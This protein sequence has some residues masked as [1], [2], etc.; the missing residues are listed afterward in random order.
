MSAGELAEYV[1][2]AKCS[3]N[4][5]TDSLKFDQLRNVRIFITNDVTKRRTTARTLEKLFD[6]RDFAMEGEIWLT[7]PEV[8]IWVGYT[9][10]TNNNP[11]SK[12][13]NVTFVAEN[14]DTTTITGTM[15][16]SRLNF[17]VQEEG[18]ALY[19]FRLESVDGAVAAS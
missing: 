17:M 16:V 13:W 5:V 7:E 4:N 1:N 3:L 8:V 14:T 19:D 18:A 2:S 11:T 9:A 12:S 6:L 15:R 10:Q